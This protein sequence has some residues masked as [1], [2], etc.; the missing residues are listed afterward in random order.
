MKQTDNKQNPNIMWSIHTDSFELALF[1]RSQG[2]SLPDLFIL[3]DA[4][5][6]LITG[7]TR[8]DF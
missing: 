5:H 8:L 2:I 6:L 3:D 1:S 7:R 4:V